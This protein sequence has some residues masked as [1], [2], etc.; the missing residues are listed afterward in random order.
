[1]I[2]DYISPAT[3]LFATFLGAWL[4]FFF[5]NRREKE[6]DSD[7]N[8]AALN[9]VQ[10]NLTQQLNSLTIFNRDFIKPYKEHPVSWIA[11]PA[12]PYRDY[13]K[14]QIDGGSLVFLIEN[15][16][17]DLIS[18]TLVVEE[19]FQEVMNLINLRSEVHV[20]R[21]QPKLE[22][23]GFREGE[24]FDVTMEEA[25]EML[26]VRL[27]TELKRLTA[28]LVSITEDAIQSHEEIIRELNECGK[29]I[30]PKKR[31]LSFEYKGREE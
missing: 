22:E 10:I 14:V 6:K 28:G 17:S 20:G 18:K 13:S 25:Q 4:A 12:A 21:L 9:K 11:I 24:P 31:V 30:F 16:A 5:Q 1:M 15:N 19:K 7:A 27:V 2:T 8:R 3:T 23:I 26:G 29:E